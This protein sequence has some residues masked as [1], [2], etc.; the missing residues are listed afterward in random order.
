MSDTKQRLLETAKDLFMARGYNAV[1]TNE[2]CLTAGVN[3][4][5]FYHFYKSKTDLALD[6]LDS[7]GNEFCEAFERIVNSKAAPI[8]L[9]RSSKSSIFRINPTRLGRENMAMLRD[10]WL[11]ICRWSLAL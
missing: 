5:T 6:A 1:G 3:K 7:Y 9:K 10:A 11:E 8:R 4:G 2:I